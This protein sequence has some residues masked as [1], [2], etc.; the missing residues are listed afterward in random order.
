MAILTGCVFCGKEICVSASNHMPECEDCQRK[1][2]TYRKKWDEMTLEEK[3]EDLN[4][5]LG[6]VDSRGALIG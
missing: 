2:G 1:H 4:R 3:V 6:D 5:R